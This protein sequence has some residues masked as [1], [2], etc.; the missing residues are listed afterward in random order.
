[1]MRSMF[2][3]VSGL[4]AHQTMMDVVGNNIA[5]VNTAGY[6]ASQVTFQEALT[7][8]MRGAASG[9]NPLQVGLGVKVGSI[10]G[11]FTQ[12][13]SQI[14]G[15]TTDLAIQGDGF[16]VLQQ[17][18][19]RVFTR[20]GSFSFDGAGNLVAPGGYNVM[21]WVADTDGTIDSN[22]AISG[23]QIPIGQVTPP[24]T[25]GR[26][27]VGGNLSAESAVGDQ[28]TT[29][30]V[31]YD[32]LGNP[33]ELTILFEKTADNAW[34]AAASVEGTDYQYP[35]QES[36]GDA[37]PELDVESLPEESFTRREMLGTLRTAIEFL[38]SPQRDVVERYYLNGEMLQDIAASMGVTE[39]RVSQVASEA[40]N[41]IRAYMKQLYDG[42]PEVPD[43][44][45]GKRNRAAYLGTMSTHTTWRGRIE[46]ADEPGWEEFA[47]LA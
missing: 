44:A 47:R 22:R 40:I 26:V 11:I 33:H 18:G 46:A 13:A 30:I 6:K 36:L 35:D 32:S 17:G 3:G 24:V 41:A 21:G 10:D 14:T 31:V 34:S 37:L 5:N 9:I 27:D 42:V 19:Q 8:L 16:F 29:S 43:N 45:P 38:P 4:R 23:I 20:A 7:Q 39:A 25:T 12:G 1:M 15:R 2:A 28:V